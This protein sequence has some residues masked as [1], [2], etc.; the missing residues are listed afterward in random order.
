[1]PTVED[2]LN[3]QRSFLGN[4]GGQQFQDWY[5]VHG[6]WCAMFQSYCFYH[7]GLPL[8]ASSNKGFAWV[9]AGFDWMREQGWNSHDIRSVKPG[10][11]LAFE[12]GSTPGGYDHI[13]ICEEVRDTGMVTI[14]GN[15][16]NA[17]QRL[18]RSFDGGG[19]VEIATPPYSQSV[20]TWKGSDKVFDFDT[21]SDGR[22]V[23]FSALF[24]QVAHRWQE[25]KNGIFSDWR[26]LNDGQPFPV[27]NISVEKNADGRFEIIAWGSKGVCYR[28]QNV[29][30]TWRPWRLEL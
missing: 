17:V 16:G 3:V 8:P 25:K 19:V 28:T 27:E 30:T 20:P 12:W 29:D 5:G 10:D 11:L 4:Q 23:L 7:A 26:L 22:I 13:G 18:W 1:M 9:S 6:A 21:T 2:V 14:E 15:V 24:G